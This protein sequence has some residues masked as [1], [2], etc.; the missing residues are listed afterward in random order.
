MNVQGKKA[1]VYGLGRTGVSA[2]LSLTR[3]GAYVYVWD[4][5]VTNWPNEL[6]G[7]DNTEICGPEV[8]NWQEIDLMVKSPGISNDAY[9]VKRAKKEGVPIVGDIDLFFEKERNSTFIGVTGTNGKSTTTALIAHVLKEA[10]VSVEMGGNFGIPALSLPS[11]GSKG[12]YVLELSSYQLEMVHK[13]SFDIAVFLNLTPD[14]LD[15]HGSMENYLAAK[16]RIFDRQNEKAIRI[17]GIDNQETKQLAKELKE[18]KQTLYSVK[19]GEDGAEVI[20]TPE[21]QLAIT[22]D[23]GL[24]ETILSFH[25]FPNMPG[26]HNWQNIACAYLATKNFMDRDTFIHGLESFTGLPHRLETVHKI[27]KVS[28]VNDSKATNAPAA[29][30][31][32][33]SY[34]DI[35]WLAGGLPKE[36]GVKPCVGQLQNVRAVFL[37]GEA[38][39][40]FY[41]ELQA[42]VPVFKCGTMEDAVKQAYISARQ[43]MCS[44][45]IIL[46]SPACASFDQFTSYEHRGDVFASICRSLQESEY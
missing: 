40:R 3:S 1:F 11:L 18:D 41:D 27:G 30:C 7:I 39:N 4:D 38:E 33:S 12:V 28:F 9:A 24:Y 37:F 32:L 15:H 25:D 44:G 26:E 35:Y 43:E 19:F 45:P 31:A 42:H 21:G 8:L 46:L 23:K 36:E 29:N 10:G 16:K 14:H 20:I 13:A 34:K 2:V 6:Q 17:I 22:N 5:K